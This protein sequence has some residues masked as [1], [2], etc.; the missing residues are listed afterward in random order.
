MG[1]SH[2]GCLK[3]LSQIPVNRR[4]VAAQSMVASQRELPVDE[5]RRLVDQ[6]MEVMKLGSL[7]PIFGRN[8]LAEVTISGVV[9]GAAVAG[10]IDRPFVDDDQVM[11][12]DFK[13]GSQTNAPARVLCAPDGTLCGA[14]AADPSRKDHSDLACLERVRRRSGG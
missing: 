1:G 7:G 4:D 3:I 14:D 6:A 5:A 9:G 12:V 10:Q 8:S 2:T 11:I 13:T